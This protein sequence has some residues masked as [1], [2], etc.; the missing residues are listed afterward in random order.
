MEWVL[1]NEVNMSE[2]SVGKY[3]I[4][5]KK[6]LYGIITC[7]LNLGTYLEPG[8]SY[9]QHPDHVFASNFPTMEWSLVDG[10]KIV[11]S[12]MKILDTEIIV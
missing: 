2:L 1:V 5:L 6:L 7:A 10:E 3:D 11:C 12:H 4:T 9:H 8:K